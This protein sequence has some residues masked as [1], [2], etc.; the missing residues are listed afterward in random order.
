MAGVELP[1]QL[2]NSALSD[3]EVLCDWEDVWSIHYLPSATP[4]S[5][6]F[7]HVQSYHVGT[8]WKQEYELSSY[9]QTQALLEALETLETTF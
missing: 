9:N 2:D 6:R 1:E 3:G 5:Y 7:I 4:Y 8:V